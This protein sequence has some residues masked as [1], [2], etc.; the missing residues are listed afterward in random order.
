MRAGA[1][2]E[3]VGTWQLCEIFTSG[4]LLQSLKIRDAFLRLRTLLEHRQH[5]S[6]SREGWAPQA[7]GAAP[8]AIV[9]APTSQHAPHEKTAGGAPGH[10]SE[11]PGGASAGA[12]RH[13]AE[14]A[15]RDNKPAGRF[16]CLKRPRTVR[17]PARLAETDRGSLF[18][19]STS[20][21]STRQSRQPGGCSL[22][23][24][25][26]HTGPTDLFRAHPPVRHCPRSL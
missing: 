7:R 14:A 26:L 18:E 15:A 2:P 3:F 25:C 16:R 24:A 23:R 5:R 19:A 10:P 1:L 6:A 21:S 13:R 9:R 12:P 8:S 4:S 17:N 20:N 22:A 11:S